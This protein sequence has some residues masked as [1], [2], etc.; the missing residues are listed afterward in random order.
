MAQPFNATTLQLAG[1]VMP[2]GVDASVNNSG[3]QMPVAAGGS[4]LVSFMNSRLRLQKIWFDRSRNAADTVDIAE[5]SG[6][7]TL[8][9]E[10]NTVAEVPGSKGSV[11]YQMSP[12]VPGA[13][14]V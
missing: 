2:V 5:M 8:S 6:H 3:V 14:S 4:L 10:G 12:S 1:D 11:R 7:E 13:I 9:P